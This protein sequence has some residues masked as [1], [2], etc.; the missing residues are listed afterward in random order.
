MVHLGRPPE[1]TSA[2]STLC[3]V[4]A[5][6][7]R[8][9]EFTPVYLALVDACGDDPGE[10]LILTELADFVAARLSSVETEANMLRRALATIE[11]C[12]SSLSADAH[13]SVDMLA[14]AFFDSFSPEEGCHLLEWL[15]PCSR[16]FL[17]QLD[18]SPAAPTDR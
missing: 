5:L 4:E 6:R 16:A 12:V 1:P 15:G 13:D 14:G 3:L 9:P 11:V 8:L 18:S 2:P 7:E 10:P 17:E